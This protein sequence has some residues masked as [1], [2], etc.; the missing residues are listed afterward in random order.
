[1]LRQLILFIFCCPFLFTACKK[2]KQDPQCIAPAIIPMQPYSYPVWHPNGQILGF[3][4]TPL[5]GI[6]ANGN[7]P[8]IWYSYMGKADST[9]F[10]LMNRYGTGF[11]RIT[12]FYL[13]TP[14]WSPDGHWIA[15]SIPPNIYKMPF[16]GSTFDTTQIIQLTTNGGNFYPSWSAN[17]DTIYFDSNNN[18]PIGTNFYS[19]WKMSNDGSGKTRLTQSA[20]IGD[21]RQ[22]FVGSN[23]RV[24]FM[25]Y[26]SGKQEIFSMSKIGADFIQ[27]TINLGGGSCPR[28][29][30]GKI[31]VETGSSIKVVQSNGSINKLT[32][33]AT[34]YDISVTGEIVYSKMEYDIMKYNKQI[35]TLW[36]MN[37]DGTNNRQLTFNNSF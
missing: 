33:P 36:I 12:N 26:A 4:H 24:Y 5:A 22:P 34:T 28:Y 3:N 29:W 23:N 17:S 19:V 21:S 31:F 13:N 37:A 32:F 7:A 11:R 6:G 25:G 14:A 8:C 1:M 35:G 10:Y 20:G 15:F 27:E 2:N 18:A 30:Q 9:G 16:N